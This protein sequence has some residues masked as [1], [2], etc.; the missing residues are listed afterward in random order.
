VSTK[1]IVDTNSQTVKAAT[2]RGPYK[3]HTLAFKQELVEASQRP[4]ASVARIARE[5][6]INANQL[7]LWRKTYREGKLGKSSSVLLP[8]KVE[9]RNATDRSIAAQ[10]TGCVLIEADGLRL[11][12]EGQPDP[13]TLRIILAALRRP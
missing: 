12:I 6:G 3:Q 1:E 8:V 5:N 13:E 7:Y 2:T 10:P 11:H 9:H 4:G